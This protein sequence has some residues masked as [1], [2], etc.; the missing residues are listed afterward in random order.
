L[1]SGHHEVHFELTQIGMIP[2][3]LRDACL[4]VWSRKL[5]RRSA[6]PSPMVQ[7]F[8]VSYQVSVIV[9]SVGILSMLAAF[10][11]TRRHHEHLGAMIDLAL[12]AVLATYMLI[13]AV[14]L[15]TTNFRSLIDLPLDENDQLKILKVLVDHNECYD[16]LGV[17]YTRT[18][19]SKKI[20]EIELYFKQD[21]SIQQIG[22]LEDRF[23]SQFNTLFADYD[24]RMI[25]IVA[26]LNPRQA[27]VHKGILPGERET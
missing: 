16:N 12:A 4:L 25:P 21:T 3:L 24:F 27:P 22:L 11:L 17:I 8:A 14:I 18:S 19:G 20:I 7:S 2:G 1:L 6:S 9:T 15:V 5:I 10:E 13:N 23:R 26:P